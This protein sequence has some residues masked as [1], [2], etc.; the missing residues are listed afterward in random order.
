MVN[1]VRRIERRVKEVLLSH[2]EDALWVYPH[3]LH[4]ML[5]GAID[6]CREFRGGGRRM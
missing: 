1:Q 2:K 6:R 4:R 3:F 5:D